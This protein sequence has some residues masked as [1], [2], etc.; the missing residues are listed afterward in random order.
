MNVGVSEAQSVELQK[1]KQGA[2]FA[3]TVFEVCRPT[4]FALSESITMSGI[5]SSGSSTGS[6]GCSQVF[7]EANKV[8]CQVKN[9]DIR[10]QR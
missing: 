1:S 5:S 2:Q 6:R 10:D 8:T 4:E 3:L 9:E 7:D